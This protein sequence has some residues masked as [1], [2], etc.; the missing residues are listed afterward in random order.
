MLTIT[1][2]TAF[3]SDYKR[4]VK[5]NKNIVK[6]DTILFHL[7]HEINLDPKYRDHKLSGNYA[8]KRECHIEPDWLLI[9]EVIESELVLYRVGSHS[10][11]FSK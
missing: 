7:C 4:A 6:L 10:E 2:T 1:Y 9:Y 3:K 5:Q 11:L 8:N